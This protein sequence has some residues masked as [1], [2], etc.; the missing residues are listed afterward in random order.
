MSAK[1]LV[2]IKFRLT[3]ALSDNKFDNFRQGC[4]DQDETLKRQVGILRLNPSDPSVLQIVKSK[5]GLKRIVLPF[6]SRFLIVQ[7]NSSIWHT[8]SFKYFGAMLTKRDQTCNSLSNRD[9]HKPT[10]IK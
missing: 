10:T 6:F 1:A 5:R 7:K 2:I 9:L 3:I 8:E 4:S